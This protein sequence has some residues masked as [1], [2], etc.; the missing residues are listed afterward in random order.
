M[1]SDSVTV[2]GITGESLTDTSHLLDCRTEAQAYVNVW[3][4]VR[5]QTLPFLSQGM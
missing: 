2:I 3:S 1:I 4:T 5:F